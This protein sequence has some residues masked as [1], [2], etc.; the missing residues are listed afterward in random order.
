VIAAR[1]VAR[2]RLP[3]LDLDK[4]REAVRAGRTTPDALEHAGRVFQAAASLLNKE[5]IEEEAAA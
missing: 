5:T 1:Y 2:V 4:L 3:A